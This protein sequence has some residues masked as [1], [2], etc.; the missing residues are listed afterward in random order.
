MNPTPRLVPLNLFGIPFGLLGLADCWL[1]AA[2]S[3]L[4]SVTI[5]RV[6]VG[7]AVVVWLVVG[8]S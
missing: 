8:L 1:V 7:V 5:G 3:H 2:T 4:A 6:L